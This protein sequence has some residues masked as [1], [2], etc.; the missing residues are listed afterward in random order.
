MLAW[1]D[2]YYHEVGRCAWYD[3]SGKILPPKSESPAMRSRGFVL[4]H[5]ARGPLV[6]MVRCFRSS[7]RT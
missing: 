6:G 1:R 7:R 4:A 2:G 5:P 3:P